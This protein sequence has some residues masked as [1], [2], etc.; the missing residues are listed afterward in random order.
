MVAAV[1]SS[2]VPRIN[3]KV[4][5]IGHKT[6]FFFSINL[7]VVQPSYNLQEVANKNFSIVQ[8]QLLISEDLGR[9]SE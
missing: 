8:T 9:D 2:T 6:V 5:V 4:A 3:G 7:L 1:N